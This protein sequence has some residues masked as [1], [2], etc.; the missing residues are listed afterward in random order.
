[1]V[2]RDDE[3]QVP[4]EEPAQ[5]DRS[6]DILTVANIITVLRLIL[7][8]MF[9]AV[10]LSGRSD[11]VAFVLFAVAAST[12]WLDGQ[13]ARR[14]GTVTAVGAAIDPLVDRLLI[15]S[16]VVGVYLLERLPLWVVVVLVARD[17]YLLGGAA[18]LARRGARSVEVV[19]VGKLTTALLL[20]GFSDL[21]LNWPLIPGIG[22]LDSPYAPGLGYTPA[23]AG[24]WFVYM[25]IAT[26]LVTAVVY[27][28]RAVRTVRSL[29]PR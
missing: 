1:M 16:G 12:D 10:L 26:S 15:A 4:T 27:T 2:E 19:F 29:A 20:F 25:G 22:I 3:V 9:F 6:H 23:A 8:P 13:I 7:V 11:G 14:T 5:S 17:V 28:I 24:I 21:I 18:Y